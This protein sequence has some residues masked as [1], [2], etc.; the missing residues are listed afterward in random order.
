[1]PKMSING[2]LNVN[3]PEG[4]TSFSVV[5]WLRH[6]SGE[7]HIGHAGTLDPMATGVLPI[8]FGQATRVVEFL[9]NAHKVYRAQIEL[10]ATSDTFDREGQI[11]RSSDPSAI[12]AIQIEEALSKFR[13][14]I[15]Q[16]PP[17]YSA[18]KYQGKRGYELARAGIP[19]E[20]KPRQITIFKLELI[21]F[22]LPT[23][24]IEVE[25]S[26]GTYVRSLAHDLGQYLGCGG[27]LVNL[28]RTQYGPFRIENALP[29]S[30]IKCIFHKGEW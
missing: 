23:L 26:K 22:K 2:I 30:E 6:L 28:I 17:I 7:K 18:L 16:S 3:K 27:Y 9:A 29:V 15:E 19:V 20:I 1:M 11:T 24:T 14:C 25:C 4:G 12:T 21:E 10:G 13:G 5:A 8:C